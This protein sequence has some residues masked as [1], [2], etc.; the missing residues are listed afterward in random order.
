MFVAGFF[1]SALVLHHLTVSHVISGLADDLDPLITLFGTLTAGFGGAWLAFRLQSEREERKRRDKEFSDAIQVFLT[2]SSMVNRL[3][4]IRSNHVLAHQADPYRHLKIPGVLGND[5]VSLSVD[6]AALSF[7]VASD[8]DDDINFIGE[9]NVAAWGYGSAIG[10]VESRS[11]LWIREFKPIFH[12]FHNANAHLPGVPASFFNS[13]PPALDSELRV[14]TDSMVKFLDSEIERIQR[15]A[16]SLGDRLKEKFP[17]YG[18][19]FRVMLPDTANPGRLSKPA[20]S[21]WPYLAQV[22]PTFSH[23]SPS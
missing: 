7:L 17:E 12:K 4:N 23:Q 20:F 19:R 1:A 16:D 21:D 2:L 15:T 22:I 9:V 18:K 11:E 14:M 8:D 5:Y 3:Y 13:L 10:A 6:S